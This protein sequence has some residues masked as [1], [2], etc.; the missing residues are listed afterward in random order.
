MKELH[1]IKTIIRPRLEDL[2]NWIEAAWLGALKHEGFGRY[3]DKYGRPEHDASEELA[4]LLHYER[5]M[6]FYESTPE[7]LEN[8]ERFVVDYIA[9]FYKV[10]TLSEVILD[11][12]SYVRRVVR[13][14][15]M[16][17]KQAAT[18]QLINS[19]GTEH[20]SNP[21]YQAMTRIAGI[22]VAA[23]QWHRMYC[24]CDSVAVRPVVRK[25]NGK[26]RLAYDVLAPNSFRVALN[27]DNEVV[28]FLYQVPIYDQS[29]G[30][31]EYVVAVWTAENHYYVTQD[32]MPGYFPEQ[33]N[34]V[35]PYGIIPWVVIS[36]DKANPY[37]GGM[38][39]LVDSNLYVNFTRCLE[40]EDMA[41]AAINIPFGVNLLGKNDDE[42]KWSAR[43]AVFVQNDARDGTPPDL[44]FVSGKSNAEMLR[45]VMDK[46]ERSAMAREGIPAFMLTDNAQELSGAA[47]RIA[48]TELLEQR[49][50]DALVFEDGERRIFDA[51]RIVVN[52]E[53]PRTTGLT[54][55]P[56]EAE[57]AID[58][59]E[60]RF[61]DD[62]I[63]QYEFDRKL[64]EDNL[65]SYIDLYR[66]HVNPDA[67][68][69]DEVNKRLQSNREQNA[70]LRL[71]QRATPTDAN[72]ARVNPN[73]G[74]Q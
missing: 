35:N 38:S 40:S 23:K 67:E 31:T 19:D 60:Q 16:L 33:P 51:T 17:Y 70:R 30:I 46:E 49:E 1:D 53:A 48:L 66:T 25:S 42:M 29:N 2:K 22:H 47:M 74:Q 27:A 39:D 28:K 64:A 13:N 26:A 65:L 10:E 56:M 63:A 44:K 9:P 69:D 52:Y 41:F 50:D 57:F 3:T 71:P 59:A 58:F 68:N 12:R 32:G 20:A 24:L 6:S 8:R 18:R 36:R 21:D 4:S 54:P 7:A 34:G 62:P 15:A 5:L 61:S 45:M 43:S 72:A 14:V 37:T 55:I 11:H 73:A